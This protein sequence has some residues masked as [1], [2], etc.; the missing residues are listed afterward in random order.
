MTFRYFA[1][2]RLMVSRAPSELW[3]YK[4]P[5]ISTRVFVVPDIAD[6]TTR[7][8]PAEETSSATC[9]ILEADP[10]EVPPNFITFILISSFR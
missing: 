2:R 9:C 1:S 8:R 10:T 5:A 3:L 4:Y 6:R 7:F